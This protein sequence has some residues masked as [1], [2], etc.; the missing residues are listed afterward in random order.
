[1]EMHWAAKVTSGDGVYTGSI[2]SCKSRPHSHVTAKHD[3][4]AATR[5]QEGGGALA[6]VKHLK[7]MQDSKGGS[8]GQPGT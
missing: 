6:P 1:M 2:L 5:R 3:I 7:G 4:K 8:R